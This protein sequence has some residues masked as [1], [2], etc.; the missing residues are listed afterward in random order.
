M[1]ERPNHAYNCPYNI[2]LM[3]C[4]F[5]EREIDDTSM[6]EKCLLTS[7]KGFKSCPRLN[8]TNQMVKP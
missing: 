5:T 4:V 3:T 2:G 1:K 7:L 8:K 6:W